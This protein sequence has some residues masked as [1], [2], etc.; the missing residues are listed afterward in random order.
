MADPSKLPFLLKLL[1]DDSPVVR[2]ALAEELSSLGPL[3]PQ[4]LA[5]LPFGLDPGQKQILFDLLAERQR[6]VLR[7]N[8]PA[9]KTLQGNAE[10]MEAAYRLLTDFQNGPFHKTDLTRLLDVLADEYRSLEGSGD[11]YRL[12]HFLFKTKGLRGAGEESYYD[13]AN[14]NLAYVIES[15]RGLPISLCA[16]YLLTGYRLGIPIEGC[17]YPGHFLARVDLGGTR[18]L[19]DC[20][21]GAQFL[22]EELFWKDHPT[23]HE[24]ELRGPVS[25]EAWMRRVLNNLLE[26]YRRSAFSPDA[27]IVQEL[28]DDGN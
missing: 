10:K 2:A 12:A 16:V 6:T 14:S 23:E 17:A 26:A 22:E 21:H 15:G 25:A 19:A 11:S 1:E 5:G 20:F 8:W 27:E 28:L 13:P 7:E 4:A 18:Y 9:W 3:L 24:Q